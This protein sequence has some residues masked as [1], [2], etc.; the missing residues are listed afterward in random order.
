MNTRH[1]AR[2]ALL[3][4]IAAIPLLVGCA[5][6]PVE[7][8][9][10][11]DEPIVADEPAPQEEPP[12]AEAPPAEAEPPA[13][14]PTA[15][16]PGA[17]PY[18]IWTAPDGSSAYLAPDGSCSGMYY[19]NGSPLDIGGPMTCVIDGDKILV[20]QPP[21]QATYTLIVTSTQLRLVSG[22]TDVTFSR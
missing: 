6:S 18:G 9:V 15:S 14:G 16:E 4:A 17:D 3:L 22:G 5:P 2:F 7:S 11:E 19:N 12:A 10:P 8:T 13:G 20:R 1:P 21:N